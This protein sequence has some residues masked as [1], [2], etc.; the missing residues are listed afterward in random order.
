M[1]NDFYPFGMQMPGRKYSQANSS[2]RYGFNGKELDKET[3]VTSAY[4]YG[5][6]IY[7]PA[8]GRFLSVDPLFKSYPELTPYQFA[9]NSPIE[10]I[11]LDGLEAKSSKKEGFW[12]SFG[13][14]V[15]R[16]ID[17][18]LSY[19]ANNPN[20]AGYDIIPKS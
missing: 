6:R 8:L 16:G 3:T 11:D 10:A 17:N 19:V 14:S 20:H 15:L 9:S 5:F 4:D 7:N 18:T 2:Y 13:K 1:A 12:K